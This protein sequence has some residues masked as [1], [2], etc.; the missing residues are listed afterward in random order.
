DT[1]GAPR[2]QRG[3]PSAV[4][5]SEA[6]R[7]SESRDHVAG[8]SARRSVED[9]RDLRGLVVGLPPRPAHAG[10]AG[11]ARRPGASRLQPGWSEDSPCPAPRETAREGERS[12][13]RERR[14][15]VTSVIALASLFMT[16][17]CGSYGRVET[18]ERWYPTRSQY[19]VTQRSVI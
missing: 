4:L 9:S 10:A 2:Q 17:G 1:G 18:I 16:S 5:A 13:R 11:R 6:D 15:L 14:W 12:W 19:R 7:L 3:L 8:R